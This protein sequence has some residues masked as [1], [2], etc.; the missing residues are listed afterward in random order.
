MR[1]NGLDLNLLVALDALLEEK[2]V[3]AAARR[4]NT[5][6]SAL[7]GMLARLRL[8]YGDELLVQT[9]RTMTLTTLGR[10]LAEPVRQLLLQ[11]QATVAQRPTLAIA[12]ER[13]RFRITVSDYGTAL[14]MGPL[15]QRLETMAP[16]ISIELRPQIEHAPQSLRNGETDLLIMPEDFMDPGQPQAHL[17]ED[18]YSCVVWEGNTQVGTALDLD[19]FLRCGHAVV[20]LGH[21]SVAPLDDGYFEEQNIVRRVAITT[22]DFT[23]LIPLIVNTQLIA[24][25]QTR[26]ARQNQARLPI[27]ILAAP[28][29][30]PALRISMQWHQYQ[31][32]DPS[33]GWLRNQLLEIAQ[34]LGTLD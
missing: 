18:T 20:R 31:A 11:I 12:T 17:F 29:P 21:P 22:H 34:D 19:T 25:T 27:R 6:Q 13:R 5:S 9:G 28:L 7:S 32:T 4:L 2:K 8:H 3:V 24:T 15:M 33:H 26:L 10:E 14:L 16:F 30:I 23:S 1:F